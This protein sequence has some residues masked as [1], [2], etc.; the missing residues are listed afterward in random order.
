MKM[1]SLEA[2]GLL[3]LLFSCTPVD[4]NPNPLSNEKFPLCFSLGLDE[5]VL[6]FTSSLHVPATKSI[7]DFAIPEPKPEAGGT[8]PGDGENGSGEN[9]PPPYNPETDHEVGDLCT[10]IEYIVYASDHPE[11]CL[12]HWHFNRNDLNIDFGIVYDTL[13]AGN[14]RIVF[15]AHSSKKANLTDRRLTFDALS[16]IFYAS[17]EPTVGAGQVRNLDFTLAR[18]VSQIEFVSTDPLPAAQQAFRIAVDRYPNTLDLQN[19]Q[20]IATAQPVSFTYTF[21]TEDV[22]KTGRRHAFFSLVPAAS[23]TLDLR[24]TATDEEGTPTRQ[25]TLSGVRPV[26]NRTLRYTGRLYS[27]SD[28]DNTFNL[29]IHNNGK[30]D[31]PQEE[32][33]P[34]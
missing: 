30:W 14:Y 8:D 12:K 3:F 26:A 32:V 29:N 25:R 20:G 28:T 2:G 23:G 7:P 24:L 18:I 9:T 6:P 22:G 34:D 27:F 15:I 11:E 17:A 16:D 4:E 31:E 13:P 19:G 5:T 33:L 21:T 10:Q 1:K